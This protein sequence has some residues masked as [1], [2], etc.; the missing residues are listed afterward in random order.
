L[1]AKPFKKL[2]VILLIALLAGVALAG[3][4]GKIAGVVTDEQTGEPLPGV[5]VVIAGTNIGAASN[6]EGKFFI[7]NVPPGKHTLK[8]NLI[9]YRPLEVQNVDVSI[10]L[11]TDLALELSTKAIDVGAIVVEA[12]R[13]IIEKDVTSTRLRITPD[14]IT[15]SVVSG[16]LN[17]AAV[18][19]GSVLGSFRGSRSGTGEVVYLLDGVN[20]TNPLGAAQGA[21]VGSGTEHGMATF[22]PDEAIAEAE[23]LTGGFGAEY[24]SVQSAVINIA[25][26]DGGQSYS[27][28]FKTKS[29]LDVILGRDN[30]LGERTYDEDGIPL[31]IQPTYNADGE[32]ESWEWTNDPYIDDYR[33]NKLFE[34]RQHDWSFGGPIPL[35]KVSIPGE[36][37]FFT[38]GTYSF[39][40]DTRDYR[41]WRKT[42]S[43]QGKLTY[44]ISSSKKITVSGL[45]SKSD[46]VLRDGGTNGLDKLLYL[47]WGKEV[48]FSGP[49][50][51]SIDGEYVRPQ[52]LAEV[53]EY[54]NDLLHENYPDT[55]LVI[56]A[57]S[58][59]QYYVITPLGVDTVYQTTPYGWIVAEGRTNDEADSAF[60]YYLDMITDSAN[61]FPVDA[62]N[63]TIPFDTSMTTAVNAAIDSL[64]NQGWARTYTGYDMSLSQYRNES[65]SDEFSI[66]F[67]NNLSPSS[68]YN[69]SFSRF[70][71]SRDARTLDPWD[72]NPLSFGEMLEERFLSPGQIEYLKFWINPMNLG[73]RRTTDD[74]QKVY[75]FK[76][77]FTSQ[78]ND[79][80]LAKMGFEYKKFDLYKEHTSIA[81]GG[82][83]YNDIFHV[84]PWQLGAYIQN[85]LESEGMIL[86]IG[87]R[88]DY[89]DPNT[90]VPSDFSDPLLPEYEHDT[91]NIGNIFNL[92]KRLKGP[93]SAKTKSQISPR[94]GVSYPITEKDVLHITYGHYFQLPMFDYFYMNHGYDLR[95]AYKY[96]GNP[97]LE[98]EKTV[99]Y[100]AGLEH[101]FNDFF[102]LAITGFFKDVSNLTN[103]KKV[104]STS[105]IIWVRSNSDY[106]RMKGFELTFSQR[107]WNNISGVATY[108]YQI[109]RGRAA[110]DYQSFQDDYNNLKP[111]TEDYPLD[112][113]QRHTARINVNY[114]IPK[115]KGYILGDWGIDVFWI[116]GSGTPY[117]S[118]NTP[119][120]PALPDIN[121]ETFPY[122]WRLD[123]R[124]D[125]GFQLYKTF[126]TKIFCEIRNVTD[127]ADII[128]SYDVKRYNLYGEPGGQFADPGVYSA[129][130]RILVGME[131]RF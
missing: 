48:N 52:T 91:Q 56:T 113:D 89:F 118:S 81:S 74:G 9:G 86:N 109:S 61:A 87:L 34:F 103:Y 127:R 22:I 36:M 69:L 51:Y 90:F 20:L 65:W 12:E 40:R 32:I 46:F 41:Y 122:S 119:P 8:V 17:R 28:K 53:A 44:N 101:G 104:I 123:L 98:E 16:I 99:A 18:N 19:A 14:E 95:G 4:T 13:P 60:F 63:N 66:K 29:S 111:R 115:D 39:N 3:T 57:D 92:E 106:A 83:S 24:P 125:K 116:Y 78:I 75:S 11:T 47:T 5:N 7:I 96:V 1:L 70:T 59:Q 71:T 72:N 21:G 26:K 124:F 55:D 105:G 88:F 128:N 114:R 100:E 121:G 85:K 120:P 50:Y 31:R 27:G 37:S 77:D 43:L 6:I 67:T 68:F 38:S 58:L 110:D 84:K 64:E 45:S 102:K 126:Q 79:A 35:D 97:N 30:Y 112:S 73:R 117:T 2:S 94:V 76:G 15:S 108:T 62:N 25:S 93:V 107:S 130:R 129:P 80:N 33:R 131:A 10:D 49:V 54:W 42:Q 23:V 82:N